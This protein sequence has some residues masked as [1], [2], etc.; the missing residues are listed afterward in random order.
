MR[1]SE[2]IAQYMKQQRRGDRD[3]AVPF[4]M[5][6]ETSPRHWQCRAHRT[7]YSSTGLGDASFISI[8]LFITTNPGMALS[9]QPGT[10][11][12]GKHSSNSFSQC[13]VHLE[14]GPP[15]HSGGHFLL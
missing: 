4:R 1:S 7:K 2:M 8:S 3:T 12:A 9:V 15:D 10:S 11:S 14:T 5:S 13:V 6:G